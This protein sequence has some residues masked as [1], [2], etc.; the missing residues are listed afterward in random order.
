MILLA[1][2]VVGGLL[3]IVELLGVVLSCCMA[4]QLAA[5]EREEDAAAEQWGGGGEY[6]DYAEDRGGATEQVLLAELP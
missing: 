2:A 1:F 4:S 5:V 3:A 6:G